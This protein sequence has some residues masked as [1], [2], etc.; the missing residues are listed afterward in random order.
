MNSLT[1]LHLCR[2]T[3]KDIHQLYVDTRY[4]LEDRPGLIYDRDYIMHIIIIIIIII[5]IPTKFLFHIL[6]L[7][8]EYILL[9][10][11]QLHERN[12]D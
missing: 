12:K 3:N 9:I 10:I 2:S 8:S 1:W 11:W 7:S 5:I 6:V 4:C